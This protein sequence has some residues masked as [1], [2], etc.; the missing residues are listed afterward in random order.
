MLQ[1]W[2]KPMLYKNPVLG[3]N[4][5][6]WYANHI[7]LHK[8][9]L[10]L[11]QMALS[12]YFLGSTEFAIR[13]PDVIMH[14]LLTLFVY[15]IG[16][17]IKNEELG[18]LAAIFFTFLNYPLELLSG[19]MG[20]DHNDFAFMFYITASFWAYFKYRKDA[21]KKWLLFIALFAGAAVLVKWL[22]GLL[23][24]LCWFLTL[25]F[26]PKKPKL[27]KT[28]L[29]PLVLSMALAFLVF[30]PWQVYC[31]RVFPDEYK[32]VM[33]HNGLHIFTVLEGHTGDWTFYF[34][35]LSKLYGDGDLVPVLLISAFIFF[36]FDK[37][38]ERTNKAILVFA[39]LF[40]Y[41][42]FT[43]VKTKMTAFP[44]IVLPLVLIV[45]ANFIL[46]GILLIKNK[47]A[48]KIVFSACALGISFLFLNYNLVTKSHSLVNDSS[49]TT[50]TLQSPV[51]QA[52]KIKEINF[53]LEPNTVLFNCGDV[54]V[55]FMFYDSKLAAAY[56]FVPGK[57]QVAAVKQKGYNVAVIRRN[58]LPDYIADDPEIRK[59]NCGLNLNN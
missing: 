33:L 12:Q 16:K 23:V 28:K 24:Y 55:M 15:D 51:L 1:N 40:V 34:T 4:H 7:W 36:V 41:T 53:L 37:K 8:Q 10:F 30:M 20:L 50:K 58:S 44:V 47:L 6:L 11:W 46:E 21:S 48:Y 43:L 3:Y 14:T 57:E 13:F 52:K 19:K 39:I 18:Y 31:Y 5:T 54:S 2:F 27:N 38:M 29:I 25:L 42:F 9:P 45:F 56:G 17:Q 59:I 35:E 26:D 49:T 32:E 22:P